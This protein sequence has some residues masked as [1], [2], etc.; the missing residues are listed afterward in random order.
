MS[1]S[2]VQ[3]ETNV[4]LP[5]WAENLF[6]RN[7]WRYKVPYGG[8]GG[9][10]SWSAARVLILLSCQGQERILCT[11]ELQTSI[12]E[13]VH[14]LLSD[15]IEEM[16]L[17]AY[18]EIQQNGIYRKPYGKN[19]KGSEFIFYGIKTN[20]TKIKSAEGI[21]LCWAEEAE[22]ISSNSWQILIPTIRT[23]G[24]E[25]W[26]TFNPDEENDPTYQRFVVSP[27]PNA[28]VHKV[29]WQ[30]NPWFPEELRLEKD[31]LYRV[32]PEAAEH[33]WGGECRQNMSV[34]I[35]RGK[36]SVE[37][38][39]VPGPGEGPVRD[40]W[41]GPYYGADWGFAQDPTVLIKF[42]LDE[43]NNRLLIEKEAYK[44][45]L[46]LDQTIDFFIQHI[47]E[48]E[49]DGRVVRADNSRPE[50]ISYLTRNSKGIR[51]T[52][53]D[54]WSGCVEDGVAFLKK[55][56]KIIIHGTNCPR[57]AEEARLY[58]YKRDR[59]TSDVLPEVLDKHNHCIA[60]DELVLTSR[61]DVAIQD[62][63][64]GD[65]VMTRT[66][67]K[68]VVKAW[69][70]AESRSVWEL[71]AGGNILKATCDHEVFTNNRGFVRMDAL[72]YDDVLLIAE[73]SCRESRQSSTTGENTVDTLT[74]PEE[75]IEC[76]SSVLLRDANKSI[77]IA[78][79]IKTFTG[80]YLK[81]STFITSMATQVITISRT[82]F[83]S[84][85]RITSWSI[86]RQNDKQSRS[87][88]AT[89]F[90]RLLRHGTLA[91][92][93]VSFT[94]A[95]AGWPIGT[96][97]R[98]QSHVCTAVE[99]S[100]L[101]K[102][103]IETSSAAMSVNRRFVENPV[104]ITKLASVDSAATSSPVANMPK[105]N[106]VPV[107]VQRVRQLEQSARV[108]DLAVEDQHEFV[109]SGILVSNCWDAIR[110]G[111]DPLIQNAGALGVWRRL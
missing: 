64:V 9:T 83:A 6:I 107:Y 22:K 80:R 65:Q 26:V 37:D 94:V 29:G 73:D 67:W 63:S 56:D 54:K 25:I 58:S 48:V 87:S 93:G 12:A 39:S 1:A 89:V 47:P 2:P 38:F 14:R 21:T 7:R 68:S 91:L 24:S 30:D 46:E 70:V 78:Q 97:F 49:R 32:D 92:K 45:G 52:A 51:F 99:Y 85:R 82:L 23:P 61:G 44:I 104:A 103:A 66:G 109:V 75:R 106:L 59:L 102:L 57:T 101:N 69:M 50:T 13:S 5:P 79:F 11:R 33:V 19:D 108:Y 18:F 3:N 35:F 17:G 77:S 20:P 81:A 100:R 15:Q 88:I 28:Y 4:Q 16:G 76:I 111:A 105:V 34:Q 53:A 43:K 31:Y 72:R 40:R 96:S 55:F 8:R 95:L 71:S 110:Y 86:G 74:I 98:S 42:W 27:P 62:V 90:D 84:L 41:D 60:E 10:K 36:Y